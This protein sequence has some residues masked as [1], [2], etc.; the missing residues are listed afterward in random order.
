M[1]APFSLA[2]G[3]IFLLLLTLSF[4]FLVPFL[5]TLFTSLKTN[6]EIYSSQIIILPTVVTLEHYVKV[7]TQM[8]EFVNFFWNTVSITFWSVA[9]TVLL[10]AMMGY[11]F[12]KLDFFG[13]KIYLMFIMIILTLPYAIY[14]IP[15]YIMENR[16]GLVDSHLGLILPYIAINLPMSIFVMRG[17]FINIPNEIAESAWIDGCNFYQVWSK[18]MLPLSRPGL[19]VVLIFAFINVWGEFMFARTLTSSPAA[20][21][22]AVG[23]TF[24]RDEAASWQ[25][26]TLCAVITLTLI[27]LLIVFLSMQNYFIEKGLM[28]GA[29]K[30]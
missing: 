18:V 9:G 22:L 5:W 27:P 16:A 8:K 10:S 7:L 2:R 6:Q 20:Q 30:G 15:I 29:L 11:A 13:K 17:I 28:E 3:I 21:T 12:G 25:Y 4:L 14:L 19:A 23:I 26:G 24:L 1:K